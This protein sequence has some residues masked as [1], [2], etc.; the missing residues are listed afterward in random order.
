MKVAVL[1][2][3]GKDST[4]ALFLALKQGWDVIY[5]VTIFPEREDSW[6]FHYPCI[7]LTKLQAKAIGIQQIVRRSSGEKEKELEDLRELLKDIRKD[8][9]GVV[10]G[11]IK[12]EYQKSRIDGICRK[13][14]LK[15]LAPLWHKDPEEVLKEIVKTGFETIITGVFAEGFDK[16]WLGRK[17]DEKCIEDLKELNKRYEIHFLGEGGEIE[18]LVLNAPIFKKRIKILE[19]EIIWDNRTQSG[20]LNIKKAKLVPKLSYQA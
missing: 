19:S 5:L 7:E 16:S 18:S 15:S 10:G 12:S 4:M 13:L 6:M 2:S 17:I 3:G 9:D 11:A 8:I 14:N 20:Y 1:Y